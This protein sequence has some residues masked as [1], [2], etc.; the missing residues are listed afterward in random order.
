MAQYALLIYTPST[1]ETELNP[2]ELAAHDRHAQEVIGSGAMVAAYALEA[3]DTAATSVRGDAVTDGPFL[4]AKE[5]I[6]GFYVIEAPDLDA[7]LD[8]AK[9]N[10]INQ[11]GGGIEVRPIEGGFI[12]DRSAQG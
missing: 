10:P 5:V 11:Q 6:A 8:I 3:A 7:A 1:R 2:D 4:D 12:V 9:S